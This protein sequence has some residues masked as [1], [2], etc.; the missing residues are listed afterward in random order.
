M[1]CPVDK[2]PM[3]GLEYDDI[4]IDFCMTCRGLWLDAGELELLFG[5]A[6]TCRA[7]LSAGGPA[8]AIQEKTRRCPRCDAKMDKWTTSGDDPVVYDH[9]PEGDGLWLDAGELRAILRSGGSDDA[10]ARVA[11]FLRGMF[12]ED[13]S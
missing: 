7:F 9:C 8:T 13:A 3:V 1:D 12:P 5:D 10:A 2:D 4:E 6:E 11:R